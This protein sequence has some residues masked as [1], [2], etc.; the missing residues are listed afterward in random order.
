MVEIPKVGKVRIDY[1]NELYSTVRKYEIPYGDGLL[2]EAVIYGSGE[3]GVDGVN[4]FNGEVRYAEQKGRIGISMDKKYNAFKKGARTLIKVDRLLRDWLKS[5]RLEISAVIEPIDELP[6]AKYKRL[7][8]AVS[9]AKNGN[10]NAMIFNLEQAITLSLKM[11]IPLANS[12][13]DRLTEIYTTEGLPKVK[14]EELELA[15]GDV[16][17]GDYSS[18]LFHLKE[19]KELSLKIGIPLANSVEDRLTEAYII[20]KLPEVKPFICK[21]TKRS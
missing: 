2:L 20:K 9:Y 6:I 12:V 15:V 11:G 8:L 14:Y 10:Y 21:L 16:K 3:E 17:Q 5:F 19:A 4:W 7:E 13:K 1:M 18:M